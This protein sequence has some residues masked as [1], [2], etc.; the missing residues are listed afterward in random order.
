MECR[1]VNAIFVEDLTRCQIQGTDV[2]K[3]RNRILVISVKLLDQAIPEGLPL[4]C[5]NT[6]TNKFPFLR[7]GSLLLAIDR[8]FSSN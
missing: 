5:S 1:A 7:P 3:W 6:G 8:R 2:D 4:G